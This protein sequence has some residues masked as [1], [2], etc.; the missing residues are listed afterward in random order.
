MSF[1]ISTLIFNKK[2]VRSVVIKF[3][4]GHFLLKHQETGH[5]I[6]VSFVNK[7][8]KSYTHSLVY[9][10]ALLTGMSNSIYIHTSIYVYL[11]PQYH[12]ELFPGFWV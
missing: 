12:L 2:Y 11:Y 5:S 6:F 7:C 9:K 1:I 8:I 10:T 4:K 3:M